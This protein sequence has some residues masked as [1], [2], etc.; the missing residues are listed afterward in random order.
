MTQSLFSITVRYLR[1]KNKGIYQKYFK[2]MTQEVN[3]Y[4]K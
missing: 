2:T 1:K 3:E 4:F